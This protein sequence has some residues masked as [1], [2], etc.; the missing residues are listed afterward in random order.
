ME[1]KVENISKVYPGKKKALQ[2]INVTLKS[3]ELIGL[4]G[5]NGAGKSTLIKLLTLNLLPTKGSITL[6]GRPLDKQE[7]RLKKSLGYLPQEY[8]LYEELTVY[9]FLD[10]IA[11]MKGIPPKETA[12]EIIRV[13]ELCGLTDHSKQR[14]GTLSGGFKQRVG[15]AQALL[16][17]P[18]LIVLD[19]P[20]VGLDPEE[21]ARMRNMFAEQAKDRILIL[22]T[23]IIEDVHSICGRL[24]VL[25]QGSICYDGTPEE[26]INAAREHVGYVEMVLSEEE[27][28]QE[29]S[30]LRIT[31]RI[32][33]QGKV[34]C[35]IVARQLPEGFALA[36]P[37]LEDAYI[38]I[39]LEENKG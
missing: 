30:E 27:C 19:E 36:E 13:M 38:Y 21:R 15:V 24:I 17:K 20:T 9:Q 34:S 6:D 2:N 12:A 5:P 31:S 1:F 25:H 29:N 11:A 7:K 39:M 37:T 4:L 18:E 10:Y 33:A 32:V 14:I 28:I 26:L 22:S 8:G 16:G 3:P 23:H 35:R